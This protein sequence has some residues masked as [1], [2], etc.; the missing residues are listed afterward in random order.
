MAQSAVVLIRAQI[1]SHRDSRTNLAFCGFRHTPGGGRKALL[2]CDWPAWASQ[3]PCSQ[4]STSQTRPRPLPL[5]C[6]G[7]GVGRGK[8]CHRNA[9]RVVVTARPPGLLPWAAPPPAR[10]VRPGGVSRNG[11]SPGCSGS[12]GLS[13][14]SPRRPAPGPAPY[15]P[16]RGRSGRR[17]ERLRE[18][19]A[20]LLRERRSARTR[21]RLVQRGTEADARLVE[22]DALAP[23]SGSPGPGRACARRPLRTIP[24]GSGRAA[25][26]GATRDP[27]DP[28]LA[29]RASGRDA[30]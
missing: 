12:L 16:P 3:R 20:R 22:P 26:P 24:A 19:R 8:G 15:P 1:Y 23:G 11:F 7:A 17:P 30:R 21:S 9:S 14:R 13:L 4:W 29:R 6:A 25:A 27:Q 10:R 28:S 5:P 18:R 2:G